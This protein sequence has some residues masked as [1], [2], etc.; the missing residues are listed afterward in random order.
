MVVD[1]QGFET[2]VGTSFINKG[3]IAQNDAFTVQKCR[4]Q[5]ALLFGKTNMHEIGFDITTINK[6]W[7]AT[8]NPLNMCHACGGSSGGSACAVA[9][10]LCPLA[11]GCDGG[12]SIRIPASF[13]GLY[14]LKPTYGRISGHGGSGIANSVGHTGPIAATAYD[15]AVGYLVMAGMDPQDPMTL[16]QPPAYLPKSVRSTGR[17]IR[18][19]IYRTYFEDAASTVVKTCNE[20]LDRMVSEM[21]VQLVDIVIPELEACR[22]AHVNLFGS[23][24]R[25]LMTNAHSSRLL[26]LSPPTLAQVSVF[27]NL[28]GADYIQACRVRTFAMKQLESIF[29]H[30]DFI[31]TPATAC[32]AMPIK[33]GDLAHG[34]ANFSYT[35]LGTRFAFLGNLTGIPCVT[36]PIGSTTTFEAF[37]ERV[38]ATQHP[39]PV[40]LQLMSTWWSEASLIEMARM[41]EKLTATKSCNLKPEVEYHLLQ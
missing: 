22:V 6:H 19:G 17:G 4:E 38:D 14:G 32:S 37:K 11:L 31:V 25:S 5:G 1:Q 26:Q 8:R 20:F 40:S 9:A 18:I 24:A 30:I 41:C 13:C 39:I 33:D 12:G 10:N 2:N 36:I 29:N 34:L 21:G 35:T 7:G 27:A 3:N 23:E 28:E 15:L 16:L